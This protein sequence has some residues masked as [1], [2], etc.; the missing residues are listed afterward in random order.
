MEV[1]L[2]LLSCRQQATIFGPVLFQKLKW[3]F[4]FRDREFVD[5]VMEF[6]G[7]DFVYVKHRYKSNMDVISMLLAWVLK[8]AES[9]EVIKWVMQLIV[10]V[11]MMR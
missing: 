9:V 8:L 4:N 10:E 5:V 1:T 2:T 11:D 6:I 7:G 3:L